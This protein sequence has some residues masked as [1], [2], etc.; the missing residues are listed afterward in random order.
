MARIDAAMFAAAL[1]TILTRHPGN[2]ARRQRERL[3]LALLDF[4]SVTTVEAIRFLDIIDPRARVYE[5]RKGGY[6]IV[7]IPVAH[8]TECGAIHVVG[9]YVLSSMAPQQS[10]PHGGTWLQLNLP[11]SMI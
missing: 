3:L 7:T 9:N 2:S 5:L 1:T 10:T 11:I 6:R 4:G 8:A